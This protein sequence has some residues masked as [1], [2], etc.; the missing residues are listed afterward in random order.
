MFNVN[1]NTTFKKC[2]SASQ[3]RYLF[4]LQK[5]LNVAR[6]IGKPTIIFE[7]QKLIVKRGREC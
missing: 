5:L 7:L 2:A 6:R 3:Q 4:Q 1:N